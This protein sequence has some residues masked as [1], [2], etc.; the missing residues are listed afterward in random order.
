MT[1][2]EQEHPPLQWKT[3]L[4]DP[5]LETDE[6]EEWDRMATEAERLASLEPKNQVAETQDSSGTVTNE[7]QGTKHSL[8]SAQEGTEVQPNKSRKLDAADRV[9]EIFGRLRRENQTSDSDL[10]EEEQKRIDRL[11]THRIPRYAVRLLKLV[12]QFSVQDLHA[13]F[14]YVR[15]LGQGGYASVHLVRNRHNGEEYAL[16]VIDKR[17]LMEDRKDFEHTVREVGIS[18]A[19][20]HPNLL[21]VWE[22]FE[23]YDSIILQMD[24]CG[25]GD[26]H[27]RIL[28]MPYYTTKSD[29]TCSGPSVGATPAAG[30]GAFTELAAKQVFHAL[31]SALSYLHARGIT[32]RDLKLENI[33]VSQSYEDLTANK[34]PDWTKVKIADMGMAALRE[35]GT[36]G[37]MY[38]RYRIYKRS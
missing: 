27:T 4:L 10:Q 24:Y 33:L 5:Y 2:Q 21:H 1:T 26:L 28:E 36:G 32:H 18:H 38:Q 9:A 19:M 31:L 23:T 35:K 37:L 20:D 3:H 6:Q 11:R 7:R 16:K 17:R 25:G 29:V 15:A 30:A 12:Q 8:G 14:D 22:C 34:T 13:G